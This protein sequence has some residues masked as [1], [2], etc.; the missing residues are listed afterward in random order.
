MFVAEHQKNNVMKDFLGYTV[1]EDR[2]K[3]LIH[4]IRSLGDSGFMSGD[5]MEMNRFGYIY[6][7]DR[8]GDTFRWKG[9]CFTWGLLLL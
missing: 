2:Q 7:T 9:S 8:M 5:L 1:E 4:N 3:K 6:F